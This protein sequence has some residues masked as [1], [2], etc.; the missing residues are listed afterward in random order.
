M[1][2]RLLLLFG[3]SFLA[4]TTLYLLSSKRKRNLILERLHLRHRRTSG[5]S[6]PPRSFAPEKDSSNIAGAEYLEVFPPSRRFTLETVAPELFRKNPKPSTLDAASEEKG[7]KSVPID[8]AFE[9]ADPKAYTPCEFSAEEIKALGDFPDYAT[10][11]GVP[12]PKPYPEFD[13]K[14]A[15]PR[16]YRPFRWAY[17]QTMSISK[18]ETDWWLELENTYIQRIKQRQELFAEH[19]KGVLDM[20]PGSELACKELMEMCLQFLC[21][22]YPQYFKLDVE[23]MLFHNSILGTVS[24]LKATPSLEVILNNVPEDFGIT[25]RDTETGYYKFRAGV[26][27]SALGWNIASKIGMTLPEIHKP[28]PDYKEKMQFSMDRYF[29]KKPTDRCIQRGSWGLEVD[30]PLY[31]PPGSPHEALRAT[32]IPDLKPSQCHLRVDWQTLRRL[33]LSG[34]IVFNFKALF[35]PIESFRDEPYIPSLL[36][37]ICREG[38]R[39]LMEYKNTWHVE[40]VVLPEL[41]KMDRDQVE[42]GLVEKGW[43]PHTLDASPFFPGWE[44]KWHRNQG[45]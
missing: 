38:K 45:Y 25:L 26:I 29:A 31:M 16:P 12:L 2:S 43:V 10:L 13:I 7:R 32:Q 15:L 37:K 8:V 39:S 19:G 6:T 27:C 18:M 21:A 5:A 24:D 33:P 17:H 23:N 22:R 3:I 4:S 28:I 42:R 9:H 20:L 30:Q 40:H 14:K 34:A 44:E 35:T 41:E 11:S 1:D 36:L